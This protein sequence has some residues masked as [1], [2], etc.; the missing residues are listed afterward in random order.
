MILKHWKDFSTDAELYSQENFERQVGDTF[1]AMRVEENQDMP[2]YIW[3]KQ[4]VI[5]IKPNTRMI[6]DVAF[7]K[8][9][10]NPVK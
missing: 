9:P 10:R 7:V 6:K 2:N 1:E 3:T 4:Y 8:V 5:I